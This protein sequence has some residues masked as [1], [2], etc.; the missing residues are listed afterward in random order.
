MK[1]IYESPKAEMQKVMP[2]D[3]ITLSLDPEGTGEELEW[4]EIVTKK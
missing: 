3:I 4:D 1:K 2:L